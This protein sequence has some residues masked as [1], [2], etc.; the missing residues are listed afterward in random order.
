MF[1]YNNLLKIVLPTGLH[2]LIGRFI[3]RRYEYTKNP[4]RVTASRYALP[5]PQIAV[6]ESAF[7]Y[8]LFGAENQLPSTRY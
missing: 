3:L 5:A 1:L 8:R 7:W 4:N 6:S 2:L